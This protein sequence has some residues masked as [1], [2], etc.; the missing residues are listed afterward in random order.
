[1]C[2]SNFLPAMCTNIQNAC[3]DFPKRAAQVTSQFGLETKDF[4]EL[5][6]R[7]KND[8]LFRFRVQREIRRIER[9]NNE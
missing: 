2:D 7:M 3:Q 6:Q 8:M 9:R 1:M 5:D 4:N